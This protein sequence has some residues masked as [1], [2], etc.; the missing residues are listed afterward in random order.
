MKLNFFGPDPAYH[1]ARE[2]F[3]FK[4]RASGKPAIPA[5]APERMPLAM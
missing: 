1:R 4:G 2:N 5:A 3:V